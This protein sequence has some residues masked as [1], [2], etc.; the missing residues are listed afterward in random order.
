MPSRSATII[1]NDVAWPWPWAEV[2]D[3]TV[4]EPSAWIWTEPNSEPP[5]PVISTYVETPMPSSLRLAGVDP[6]LLLLAGVVDVGDPQ[7]LLRGELGSR[8]C[9]RSTPVCVG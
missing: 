7:R 9:R 4:A 2:P 5:K 1:E 6:A 3:M 8:R